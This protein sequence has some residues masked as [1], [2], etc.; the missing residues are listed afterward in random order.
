M[1]S[2]RAV[3][4]PAVFDQGHHTGA[5]VYFAN[6]NGL[7]SRHLHFFLRA[8]WILTTNMGSYAPDQLVAGNRHRLQLTAAGGGDHQRTG[9][10]TVVLSII[11]TSTCQYTQT[12][13][14]L[15]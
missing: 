11:Y 2:P 5:L 3:V 8:P 12:Y 4:L 7:I 10:K 15:Q 9:G 6:Q 14:A 13:L 1:Y